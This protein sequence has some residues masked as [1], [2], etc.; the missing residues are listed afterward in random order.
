[1]NI[2]IFRKAIGILFQDLP[3][4]LSNYCKTSLLFY[5]RNQIVFWSDLSIFTENKLNFKKKELSLK[6]LVTFV[7]LYYNVALDPYL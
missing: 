2:K 7:E 6:F 4:D 5:K 1:M 3:K